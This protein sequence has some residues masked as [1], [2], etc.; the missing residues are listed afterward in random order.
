ME[1][2][3]C[4]PDTEGEAGE[5]HEFGMYSEFQASLG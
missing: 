2:H 4:H 3:D 1:G 5:S